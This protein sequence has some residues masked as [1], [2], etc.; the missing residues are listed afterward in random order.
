MTRS[1]ER[2]D[3]LAGTDGVRNDRRT[4]LKHLA[5][6]AP[7]GRVGRATSFDAGDLVHEQA[8]T[9]EDVWRQLGHDAANTSYN[10]AATGPSE[11]IEERWRFELPD[12]GVVYAPVV[13]GDTL[14]TTNNFLAGTLH[15]I[16]TEDGTERWQFSAPEG[17][18]GMQ[19][20]VDDTVYVGSTDGTVYALDAATGDPRWLFVTSSDT[21]KNG[22]VHD[23]TV[24]FGDD[25]DVKAL[26]ATTGELRWRFDD[27][28]APQH[29][30]SVG[31]GGVYVPAEDENVYALDAETGEERWR[32]EEPTA[33]TLSTAVADGTVYVGGEDTNVYAVDAETGEERWRFEAPTFPT[34]EPAVADDTIYIQDLETVYAL[35]SETGE[36]RWRF[37]D[38][39]RV[40]WTL[41]TVVPGTIYVGRMF[42]LY[43]LD[44]AS[45]EER[46]RFEVR[47]DETYEGKAFASPAVVDDTAYVGM[48]RGAGERP[49][50]GVILAL[51]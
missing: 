41:T 19:A 47:P 30:L 39:H 32:F 21:I 51:E 43:A 16:A 37:E 1:A 23:D 2:S 8:D 48:T 12:D 14:Y 42:N 45:G 5:L 33:A 31:S 7:V 20:V 18:F 44:A 22:K 6:V 3:E 34:L 29:Y 9:G 26:D 50:R 49:L 11:P 36:E 17:R 13:A 27:V 28:D 46:W 25:T 10:P 24:Y 4:F 38:L 40:T 35:S 15:A